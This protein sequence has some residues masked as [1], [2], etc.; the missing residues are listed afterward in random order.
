MENEHAVPLIARR[1]IG[2]LVRWH[3]GQR[4]GLEPRGRQRPPGPAASAGSPTLAGDPV[5]PWL[6]LLAIGMHLV[7]SV[8]QLLGNRERVA[9]QPGVASMT[10]ARQC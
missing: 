4:G 9:T 5:D 6:T 8:G 7:G 2:S 1:R 10:V 3:L